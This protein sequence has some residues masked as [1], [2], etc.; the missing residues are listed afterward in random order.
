MVESGSTLFDG[1]WGNNNPFQRRTDGYILRLMGVVSLELKR[2][3]ESK[4]GS[5]LR[6]AIWSEEGIKDISLAL[7]KQGTG[8]GIA[9]GEV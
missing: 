8:R 1:V 2:R 6:A 5:W 9:P 4:V 7:S 3:F